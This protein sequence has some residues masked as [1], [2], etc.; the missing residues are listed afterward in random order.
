MSDEDDLWTC[1]ECGHQ[2]VTRNS[3]HSCANYEFDRHF[4]G[5][6]PIVLDMF[7]KF[8]EMV[9]RCGPVTCY[10]QKTRIVFQGRM[11]FGSCQTRKK[12]LLCTL[13][14][15][16]EYPDHVKLQK[17]EYYGETSYGHSFKMEHP[18]D[19]DNAFME[20]I[21]IAYQVG[22]QKFIKGKN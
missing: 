21:K 2:F 14:L 6:D 15:P 7:H 11:R 10:P 9:E 18:E 3:W 4:E 19:L 13:L 5:K 8:K 12:Y 17:I 22:Q 16:K 20:L 1:P